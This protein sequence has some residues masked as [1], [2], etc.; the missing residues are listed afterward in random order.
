MI[1]VIASLKAANSIKKFVEGGGL[2][3][4]LA[5]IGL[6][7]ARDALIKVDAAKQPS[8]QVWSAIN[9]LEGAEAALSQTFRRRKYLRWIDINGLG[10]IF[11]RRQIIGCLMAICYAYLGERQLAEEIFDR[12]NRLQEQMFTEYFTVG[13]LAANILN[14]I[15]LGR[16]AYLTIS[17]REIFTPEVAKEVEKEVIDHMNRQDF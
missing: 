6:G 9:H 10:N 11:E 16:S 4:A 2:A 8:A 14:P 17:K 1:D 5:D 7:A 12:L 3:I 15:F 13:T